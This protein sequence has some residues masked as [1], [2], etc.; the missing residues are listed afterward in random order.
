MF[1]AWRRLGFNGSIERLA[2]A[3]SDINDALRY[4]REHADALGIDRER[5]A[6]WAFSGGGPHLSHILR[7]SETGIRCIVGFY[8]PLDI[9]PVS[10]SPGSSGN[11]LKRFSP[12]LALTESNG[13]LP[14]ILLGRAGRDNAPLNMTIDAFVAEGLKRNITINISN[15]AEGHHGFDM[16]DDNARSREV[17]RHAMDFVKS[18]F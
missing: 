14:P 13:K 10:V 15:H 9:Q 17:I 8:S 18:H 3:E 7:K 6:V 1:P 12:V 4:L 16:L 11:S 2:D 5:I